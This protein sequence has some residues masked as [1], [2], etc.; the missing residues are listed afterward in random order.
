MAQILTHLKIRHKLMLVVIR[1]MAAA[2]AVV[3][4]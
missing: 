3:V 4:L 2:G 1:V